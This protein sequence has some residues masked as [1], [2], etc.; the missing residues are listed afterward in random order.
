MPTSSCSSTPAASSPS[1][2]TLPSLEDTLNE[3]T[4]LARS[5]KT[6][7][8]RRQEL[9]DLLDQLVEAGEAEEKMEWNDYKI[10]RRSKKSYIYPESILEQREQLKSA[11]RLSVAMGEAEIK[12]STYWEVRLPTL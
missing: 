4:A 6:L 5:E 3:L 2:S 11:E 8:A 10:N 1:L 12:I 9:L 7:Q